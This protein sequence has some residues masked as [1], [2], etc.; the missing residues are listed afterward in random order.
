MIATGSPY[1]IWEAKG[2]AVSILLDLDLVTHLDRAA[3]EAF[4]RSRQEVEGVLLGRVEQNPGRG[5]TVIIDAFELQERGALRW[6]PSTHPDVVGCF[7]ST[8]GAQDLDEADH[9]IIRSCSSDSTFVFLQIRPSH[10]ALT[11]ANFFVLEK[12]SVVAHDRAQEFPLSREH[13]EFGNYQRP[14]P[15]PARRRM[16]NWMW[17][18]AILG[19]AIVFSVV[20]ERLSQDINITPGPELSQPGSALHLKA[21]KANGRQFRITWDGASPAVLGAER[22]VLCITDGGAE[23]RIDL[24]RQQL[25]NGNALYTPAAD[26]NLLV[27]LDVFDVA[28]V[29]SESFRSQP[30]PVAPVPAVTSPVPEP[31]RTVQMAIAK[32]SPP[33]STQPKAGTPK[34][35]Q[36]AKITPGSGVPETRTVPVAPPPAQS[37][38]PLTPAPVVAAAPPVTKPHEITPALAPAPSPV[39]MPAA[40]VTVEETGENALRKAF[41]VI[42]GLRKLDKRREA[43]YVAAVPLKQAAPTP[44]PSLRGEL[45]EDV[46]VAVRVSIDTDGYVSRADLTGADVDSRLAELALNAARQWRF[47]PAHVD[48][49][50]TASKMLLRFRFRATP[51]VPKEG[52]KIANRLAVNDAKL[53]R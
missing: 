43:D 18:P 13:L 12:G 4:F 46:V 28:N 23:H 27:R 36:T 41:R 24:N 2:K 52:P 31:D 53:G 50:P 14:E 5:A 8:G 11:M 19:G 42:P 44:P 30:Y 6:R 15:P 7:R 22:G 40:S 25:A 32:T 1:F 17:V 49:K 51:A 39:V 10:T 16:P 21:E 29:T 47:Q 3:V 34:P 33:V 38:A 9:E 35:V 45:S 37:T 20:S 48:A 26:D